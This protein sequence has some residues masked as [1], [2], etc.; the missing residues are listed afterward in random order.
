MTEYDQQAN[1]VPPN[2]V[3]SNTVP[4][5]TVPP[6]TVPPNTMD[7]KVVHTDKLRTLCERSL[8]LPTLASR[9]LYFKLCTFR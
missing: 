5:N 2:T 8:S 9:Q 3:A 6:N 4:P 7:K 1:T